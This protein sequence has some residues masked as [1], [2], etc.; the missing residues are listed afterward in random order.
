M[1]DCCQILNKL[2]FWLFIVSIYILLDKIKIQASFVE[3]EMFGS[4][5]S[6]YG[7]IIII[8]II[9]III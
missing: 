1:E 8:I 4:G 2:Q 9:I 3:L 7:D 5:G 6:R